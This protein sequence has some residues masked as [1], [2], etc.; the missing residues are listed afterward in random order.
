[1]NIKFSNP[2]TVMSVGRGTVLLL[3]V[4]ALLVVTS[5]ADVTSIEEC[6]VPEPY[7]FLGGL[8]HGL[9]LPV[10]FWGSILSDDIAIYGVNNTGG[11]YDF[12]FCLGAIGFARLLW[13]STKREKATQ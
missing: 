4:F 2:L 9:I 11:W 8:W 5:C 13:H 1:M 6:R 3:I 10:S 7:G 12:G